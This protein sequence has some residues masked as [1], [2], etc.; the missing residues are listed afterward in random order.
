MEWRR[1]CISLALGVL[2]M[3]LVLNIAHSLSC[4]AERIK[5]RRA[6]PPRFLGVSLLLNVIVIAC[7]IFLAWPEP[8]SPAERPV[9]WVDQFDSNGRRT[10]H[11]I[12]DPRTGRIDTFDA[13]SRKTGSGKISPPSPSTLSTSR[14]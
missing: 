6:P 2:T 8:S 12:V 7:L 10:G 1:L 14:L 11:A 9:I 3:Y 4:I 13:R 5:D